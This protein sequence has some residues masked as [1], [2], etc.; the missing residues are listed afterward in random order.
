MRKVI[1]ALDQVRAC[2]GLH[3]RISKLIMFNILVCFTPAPWGLQLPG[4]RPSARA[5]LGH[6]SRAGHKG[7]HADRLLRVLAWSVLPQHPS[8]ITGG[9]CTVGEPHGHRQDALPAVCHARVARGLESQGAQRSVGASGSSATG[10][11]W[12]P[13]SLW[14]SSHDR[15]PLAPPPGP[16]RGTRPAAFG[17]P[18]PEPPL[19]VYASRTHS[20]LAQVIK[21]LR[22]TNYR[23][24]ARHS[25]V[26]VVD[27]CLAPP[28]RLA[29]AFFVA[30]CQWA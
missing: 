1:L 15:V 14:T 27:C 19:L 5:M 4:W 24:A 11:G 23:H 9:E 26:H 29:A 12:L 7:E 8:Y 2:P 28:Q 25:R 21:E 20:P 16:Q 6:A 13:C 3:P 10:S 18:S 17:A 30:R 22:T